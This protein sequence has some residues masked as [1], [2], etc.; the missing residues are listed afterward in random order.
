M[1]DFFG[2]DSRQ[3]KPWVYFPASAVDALAIPIARR[4]K[5]SMANLDGRARRVS[6]GQ[7][8]LRKSTGGHRRSPPFA[9]PMAR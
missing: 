5:S 2:L 1:I 4:R 9:V 6:A 8:R 3:P 7:I